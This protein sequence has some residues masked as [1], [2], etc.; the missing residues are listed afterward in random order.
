MHPRCGKNEPRDALARLERQPGPLPRGLAAGEHV[1]GGVAEP[2]R[3]L[4]GLMGVVAALARAIEQEVRLLV[5]K[6]GERALLE[7]F[8]REVR[9][10]GQ[11]PTRNVPTRNLHSQPAHCAVLSAK[12]PTRADGSRARSTRGSGQGFDLTLPLA[13]VAEGYRAGHGP[14]SSTGQDGRAGSSRPDCSRP[15]QYRAASF[16][17]RTASSISSCRP[18]S[19]SQRRRPHL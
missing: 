1:H 9:G 5:G 16:A 18:R 6:E 4:L 13:E 15:R 8:Q 12:L 10:A 19:S 14:H 11:V 7:A 3:P 2:A 17:V